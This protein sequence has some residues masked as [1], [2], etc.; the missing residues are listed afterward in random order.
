MRVRVYI[1]RNGIRIRDHC[2]TEPARD[3]KPP[4]LGTT[5]C[6]GDRASAS[7]AAADGVQAPARAARRRLRRVHGGRTAPPL[8]AETRTISGGGCLAGPVP[9]VLV[10][11]HRCSRTLPRSLGSRPP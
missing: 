6:G 1:E 2:G 5:V 3:I 11:S 7:Y 8:P 10:R 4:R 9:T